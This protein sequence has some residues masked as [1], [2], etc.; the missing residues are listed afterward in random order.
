MSGRSSNQHQPAAASKATFTNI[1]NNPDPRP[2][3][4][5]LTPLEYTTPQQLLPLVQKLY[6]LSSLDV[7]NPKI[8][9]LCCS[10]GING[11]ILR[12]DTNMDTWAA[13][14][15]GSELNPEEQVMAD[16][17]FFAAR[18]RP[19]R[20]MVV[21]LDTS[22]PAIRYALNTGLI[23]SGWSENLEAQDPSTDLSKALQDV[24]LIICTG[25]A[26]YVGSSTFSRIMRAIERPGNVWVV[27][28]VIKMIS[29]D[30]IAETLRAHGLET[31]KLPGVVLRQRKFVSAEEESAVI[32]KIV[33]RGLDTTGFEDEGYLCAEVFVSRPISEVSRPPVG[34]LVKEISSG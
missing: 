8:L 6:Q 13:H 31:E 25:G 5:A 32:E 15:D 33:A 9:D 11:G 34:E 20:P 21:G 18:A 3:F 23:D 29:Y 17:K 16:K 7:V 1:Y 30:D 19:F 10:Y 22:E 26:S 12:H 2:Y 28:T 4:Q 24:S 27:C 14:Y